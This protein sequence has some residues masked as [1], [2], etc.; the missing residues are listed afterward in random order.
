VDT[1]ALEY[2]ATL[3]ELTNR[4]QIDIAQSSDM[5]ALGRDADQIRSQRE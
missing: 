2:I 1:S 4:A 3:A 5:L